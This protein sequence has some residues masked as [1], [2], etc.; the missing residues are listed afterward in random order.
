MAG[1]W[2]G[3]AD[4]RVLATL[5]G[6]MLEARTQEEA[7]AR[8][9]EHAVAFGFSRLMFASR[10]QGGDWV[11]SFCRTNYPADY[12]AYSAR[13]GYRDGD[14]IRKYGLFQPREF[15]WS[16]LSPRMTPRERKT[17]RTVADHGLVCGMTVPLFD[18]NGLCGGISFVA[19]R[20]AREDAV[21]KATL[22]LM[23]NLYHSAFLSIGGPGEG[24][25]PLSPREVEILKWSSQGAETWQIGEIL[26][27][28]SKGVEY[29]LR[30]I[31]A[32]LGVR[33]RV[34]AVVQAIRA[35][36]FWP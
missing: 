5:F 16:E 13:P 33:N 9:E 30:C 15:W 19:D 35:G 10:N 34:A 12:L 7:F 23:G 26:H 27:I 2:E 32:K 31:F 18:G 28:S 29:N 17:M 25:R 22:A 11:N 3:L 14:P 4:A 6:Q 24:R 20:A 1:R 36:Y 21:M 8:L